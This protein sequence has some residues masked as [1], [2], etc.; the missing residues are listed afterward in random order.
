VKLELVTPVGIKLSEEIYEVVLPTASGFIT[1]LPKHE[2]LVTLLAQ[3]VMA[4]RRNRTDPDLEHL[5]IE[6][7]IAEINGE[8]V[9]ILTDEA[10]AGDEVVEREIQ[11][12]LASAQKMQSQAKNQI[13]LEKAKSLVNRQVARL[14]VAEMHRRH[15]K[16]HRRND[17]KLFSEQ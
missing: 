3:G 8:S 11:A 12:A 10:V 6:R 4:V 17:G 9:R 14:K 1:V 2:P 13:E 15:R 16:H 5:A 7:G